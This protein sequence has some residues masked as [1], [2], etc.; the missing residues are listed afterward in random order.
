MRLKSII[1]CSTSAAILGLAAAPALAQSGPATP[2]DPAVEAQE[3]PA[4]A[5]QGS[6]QTDDAVQGADGSDQAEEGEVIVVTGLR[7]SLQSAQ[8][9]RRNSEQ[10]VDAIVA[11]DIGKLP[12]VTA[13]AALARIPGVQANRA[14][15]EAAEVRIRGLP[16]ISTTYN[17]REIFTRDERFVAIQDF[18]AGSVAALEVFKSG[19]ANQVE[20]GLGGQVNVRSRRPFDFTGFELSG[21]LNAVKFEQS[22]QWDW[23]G[24]ILASNRWDVGDGGEF[25]I[26]VNFA[27]TN[28]DFLDSTREND[29]FVSPR[30]ASGSRPAFIAPN[31]SGLFY[32]SGDRVRPSG[33]AAIQYKPNDKLQFYVDGL[34]QGYRGRDSNYW[35]FVP[36]FSNP[37]TT[38]S[39][40]V[41][42]DN[43]LPISARVSTTNAPDGFQEFRNADTDTYQIGGGVIFDVTDDLRL[44]GDI[45]YT[46]SVYD[47]RQ[48]NIDYALASSPDRIVVFDNPK[49]PGGVSF[50]YLNFDTTNPANYLYR[51]LFQRSEWRKG[52][53]VQ[54]RL[55]AEYDTPWEIIPRIQIGVRHSNRDAERREGAVYRGAAV[56]PLLSTLPIDIG[57][58]PCGFEYDKLQA[59]TCFIGA[60][61]EDVFRNL[62]GLRQFATTNNPDGGA[63]GAPVLGQLYTANEKSYAGYGQVR[64][65]FDAGIPIDGS[66]GVRVVRT[67]S[68][69]VGNQRDDL[70]GVVSEITRENGYTDVLPNVSMRL[71]FLENLQG[72]LAYTETRTRPNF[73]DLNPS[74]TIFPRSGGCTTEGTNSPNCFQNANGGNPDLKPIESRNFDATL[75]YYFAKQGAF[76]LSLFHRDVK[77]FIFRSVQDI[78]GGGEDGITL[79]LDAP[80]NTGNGKISGFEAAFTTFFD[81]DWLPDFAR[82]FGVQ[83]NYTYID[84]STELAPQYSNNQLK[85]QQDFPGVSKHSYNLVGMYERN[86]ISARLAYNWR[87]DFAVEPR[88]IQ[89]NQAFLR[90]DSLGTLDFSASYTP[91]ENLTIAVDA[92][93]L[94]AGSQPIRTYRE[95]AGG[96]GATF[97]FQRKYLERVFS[98]GIRFRY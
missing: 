14:A 48:V 65:E 57:P 94:L 88:D 1:L 68:S 67:E 4:D 84:A 12:D 24:N 91:I 33:N 9:I 2:V 69:L 81:F 77:N 20:G 16:D 96:N 7:R 70:T 95:F 73:S 61:Y 3:S 8:N 43:G 19:T 90:Q 30:P 45:A 52:E 87:S 60:R 51:G 37:E 98:V 6:A 79:R 22:G 40:V 23:N 32:G 36:L 86:K 71:G 11:E 21:Q 47:E 63:L 10:I 72:R 18:P 54:M 74:G 5:E 13:S 97:P 56:R 46:S 28:T 66:I 25:G 27:L 58:L 39:D 44:T 64:Y 83:A 34:F 29:L 26:L 89:G 62:D 41:L 15:G 17:G 78:P 53:D 42:G 82:G 92:L 35:Q 49:S 55:D 50:D 93:N 59:E 76:T 80:F 85:G 31:G 75:E 38:I